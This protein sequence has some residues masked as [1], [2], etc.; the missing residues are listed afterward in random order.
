MFAGTQFFCLIAPN[1]HTVITVFGHA[2]CV[3]VHITRRSDAL[4]LAYQILHAVPGVQT[5]RG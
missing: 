2:I 3:P 4:Q 1:F 5:V